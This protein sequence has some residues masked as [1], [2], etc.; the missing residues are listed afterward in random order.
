MVPQDDAHPGHQ[1]VVPGHLPVSKHPRQGRHRLGAEAGARKTRPA[2]GVGHQHG[3][4]TKRAPGPLRDGQRV[5]GL[6][7]ANGGVHS[8]NKGT[9]EGG[10]RANDHQGLQARRDVP[11]QRT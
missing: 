8:V 5:L 4:E 9:H 1:E 10:R 2:N 6:M 11:N 7:R 3:G